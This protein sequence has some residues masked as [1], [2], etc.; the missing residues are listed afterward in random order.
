MIIPNDFEKKLRQEIAV[1]QG[2]RKRII[3]IIGRSKINLVLFTTGAITVALFIVAA[4]LQSKGMFT[5]TTPRADMIR[6]GLVLSDT[7]DF[8]RPRH[9]LRSEPVINMWNI[10][11]TDLPADLD[12]IDGEHN[13]SDYLAY[14]FYVKNVG[15]DAFTYRT[16]LSIDDMHLAVDNAMRVKIYRNGQPTT[17]AKRKTDGSDVPEPD[18]TPFSGKNKII[19]F[20]PFDLN[21]GQVDKYTVVV[22][23]EGEDPECVNDILG[24]FVKMSM[25]FR[26]NK[27]LEKPSDAPSGANSTQYNKDKVIAE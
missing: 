21:V 15:Q 13:G 12:L 8:A 25:D 16:T 22:W 27:L 1:R 7:A 17:Y 6:L 24:G 5:I 4:L 20:D 19:L 3:E 2:M 11:E 14:T 10:T 26:A 23:L 18:T 9:E